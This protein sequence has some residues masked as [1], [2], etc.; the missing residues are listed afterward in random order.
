MLA[1]YL[2]KRLTDFLLNKAIIFGV[3]SIPIIIYAPVDHKNK[4]LSS[5]QR[6]KYH[7]ICIGL[8]AF[9]LLLFLFFMLNELSIMSSVLSFSVFFISLNLIIGHFLNREVYYET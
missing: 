1:A 4:R 8:L 2:S 3:F 9:F 6:S 7:K 5:Q